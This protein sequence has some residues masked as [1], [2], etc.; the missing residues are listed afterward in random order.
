MSFPSNKRVNPDRHGPLGQGGL[1]F[2]L[3]VGQL[4]II[5]KRFAEEKNFLNEKQTAIRL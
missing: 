5:I 3:P 1:H 2:H 4:N